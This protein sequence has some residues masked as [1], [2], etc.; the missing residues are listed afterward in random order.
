MSCLCRQHF[1]D[2]FIVYFI[3]NSSRNVR[4][5]RD[6]F[7][8]P[9]DLFIKPVYLHQTRFRL[10]FAKPRRKWS[11]IYLSTAHSTSI[12]RCTCV[13]VAST[14]SHDGVPRCQ[15]HRDT[16]MRDWPTNIRGPGWLT[17][18]VIKIQKR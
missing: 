15:S 16:W 9:N 5:I 3:P 11:S 8:F 18:D 2:V 1:G 13:I 10:F 4:F 6:T 17:F 12:L 7:A 14:M